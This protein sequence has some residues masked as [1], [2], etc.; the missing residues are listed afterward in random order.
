LKPDQLPLPPGLRKAIFSVPSLIV[1]I[2]AV[3]AG[4][5]PISEMIEGQVPE[6]TIET[7]QILTA[8]LV[9]TILYSIGD[10]WDEMFFDK[11]YS[12][13]Y[14]NAEKHDYKTQHEGKWLRREDRPLGV[15]PAGV[16]LRDARKKFIESDESLSKD[17][18][19]IYRAAKRKLQE[20]DLWEHVEAPIL[21]SKFIRS[22]IWPFVLIAI[23]S[24]SFYLWSLITTS[25]L[26]HP[27][28]F[29]FFFGMCIALLAT[30]P[31]CRFRV[32]HML[33]LYEKAIKTGKHDIAGPQTLPSNRA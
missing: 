15:Y 32:E 3:Y 10:F 24:G 14:P 29:G 26:M 31:Y 23:C 20:A 12:V 25:D 13:R 1:P 6:I 4:L 18:F 7:F 19:G 30:V 21:I 5:E 2:W 16:Q 22:F 33:S 28:I 11:L 8:T 27:S 9:G 17:G